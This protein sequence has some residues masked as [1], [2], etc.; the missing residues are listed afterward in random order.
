MKGKLELKDDTVVHLRERG[1]AAGNKDSDASEGLQHPLLVLRLTLEMP[2]LEMA[3]IHLL[4]NLVIAILGI[5]LKQMKVCG[6]NS[7][8]MAVL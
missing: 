3:T 6:I 5:Y 4:C 8:Y 2:S 7:T 1:T